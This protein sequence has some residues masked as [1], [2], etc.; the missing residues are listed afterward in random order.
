[1]DDTDLLFDQFSFV[2]QSLFGKDGLFLASW[3][4]ALDSCGHVHTE[5]GQAD[6]LTQK[7][8]QVDVPL[9]NG[10]VFL[11]IRQIL[12]HVEMRPRIKNEAANAKHKDPFVNIGQVAKSVHI[13]SKWDQS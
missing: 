4:D 11:H 7:H 3:V 8:Q 12:F 1:M 2:L 5:H 6:D 13:L 9:T 10:T